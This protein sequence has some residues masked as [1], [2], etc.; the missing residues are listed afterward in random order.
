MKRF[1][2]RH[3]LDAWILR[4]LGWLWCELDHWLQTQGHTTVHIFTHI[5]PHI[6]I[7]IYTLGIHRCTTYCWYGTCSCK[8]SINV[9]HLSLSNSRTGWVPG[10]GAGSKCPTQT[11]GSGLEVSSKFLSCKFPYSGLLSRFVKIPKP[12]DSD[13]GGFSIVLFLS[14]NEMMLKFR[15]SHHKR[16][17][18]LGILMFS[19]LLVQCVFF[20]MADVAEVIP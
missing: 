12:R 19:K 7:Y 4:V 10:P 8:L 9:P 5:F 13:V 11:F 2:G 17:E 14:G 6:Y 18:L 1:L 15:T 20:W 3:V 16:S